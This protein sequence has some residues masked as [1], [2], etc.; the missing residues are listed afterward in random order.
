ML[1][2]FCY[3]DLGYF[4]TV[5]FMIVLGVPMPSSWTERQ[6]DLKPNGALVKINKLGPDITITLTVGKFW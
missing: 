3:V 4:I 6:L 2:I 1:G 5:L